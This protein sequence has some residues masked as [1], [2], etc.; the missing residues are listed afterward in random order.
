M[1]RPVP[2]AMLLTELARRVQKTQR[3][4]V[5]S[6][7][8]LAANPHGTE[9]LVAAWGKP[10]LHLFD[11]NLGKIMYEFQL[12]S[13]TYM[14]SDLCKFA[15]SDDRR[16]LC[17]YD[18]RQQSFFVWSLVDGALHNE[19]KGEGTHPPVIAF[20]QEGLLATADSIRVRVHRVS[21][22]QLYETTL[23]DDLRS[24]SLY[25]T[26]QLPTR[27][28]VVGVLQKGTLGHTFACY[29]LEEG[30][31]VSETEGPYRTRPADS[32]FS[33]Y[34]HLHE[35]M[36]VPGMTSDILIVLEEERLAPA[37]NPEEPDEESPDEDRYSTRLVALN[38]I[39]SQFYTDEVSLDG[40]YCLE[41]TASALHLIDDRGRRRQIAGF[42]LAVTPVDWRLTE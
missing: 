17:G 3:R 42:P 26:Y 36:H 10:S 8:L 41:R 40:R 24:L 4:V 27:V 14:A 15:F 38:P 9:A 28:I 25:S 21:E 35:M 22:G 5:P 39:T 7:T 29:H 30:A 23:D 32:G 34:I 2:H 18:R 33:R 13:S 6:P 11:C 37:I 19:V 16:W 31:V 20:L 12:P 1:P